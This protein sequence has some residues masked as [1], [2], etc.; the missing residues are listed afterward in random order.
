MKIDRMIGI[1]SILL[2]QEKVT[3][4]YLVYGRDSSGDKA[5]DR[6]R[7]LDYGGI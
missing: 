3:A 2:Q 6:R 5:G 1:L 4:S 7:D